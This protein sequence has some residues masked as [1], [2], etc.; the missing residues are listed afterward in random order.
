MPRRIWVFA[1]RT[2]TLLVLSCRGS[3]CI[4]RRGPAG[5]RLFTSIT[6][7]SFCTRIQRFHL[8]L[9][10]KRCKFEVNIYFTSS[11]GFS[12]PLGPHFKLAFQNPYATHGARIAQSIARLS[13][14]L[15]TYRSAQEKS[16][17]FAFTPRTKILKREL[18]RRKL[19][20]ISRKFAQT[21][22]FLRE[23]SR[24]NS[25]KTRGETLR[26]FAEFLREISRS[27]SVNTR[28]HLKKC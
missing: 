9:W 1:G 14:R 8:Q 11:A 3:F 6:V 24:R 21:I 7:M 13:R 12:L 26:T 5:Q 4:I 28:S 2:V 16:S 27:Y 18:S 15:A 20:E 10:D 25:A 22:F 17:F 23:I 19:L